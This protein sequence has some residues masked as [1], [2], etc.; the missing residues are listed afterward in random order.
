MSR[1]AA[2]GAVSTILT[3]S[4]R[5]FG[6]SRGCHL[7][8]PYYP[9][10]SGHNAVS[11]RPGWRS[12]HTA[13]ARRQAVYV[14]DQGTPSSALT[15][16]Y[17]PVQQQ[18]Q[19][20]TL[21]AVE[22]LFSA[23]GGLTSSA[24]SARAQ[25]ALDRWSHSNTPHSP[26]RVL[27]VGSSL[28]QVAL[29]MAALVDE[30]L[31]DNGFPAEAGDA[32]TVLH[33]LSKLPASTPLAFRY[34]PGPCQSTP[35]PGLYTLDRH[36][37]QQSRVELVV[38]I[39]PMASEATYD[40][41]YSSDAV[42]FVT[43]DYALG[44]SISA[45][46]SSR[47][48]NATHDLAARFADKPNAHLVVNRLAH[49]DAAQL[50]SSLETSLGPV[51]AERLAR[52]LISVSVADATAAH[53][54]FR[55]ALV[56]DVTASRSAGFDAAG[57]PTA[58]SHWDRFAA[59]YRLSNVGSI[60]AA[61]ES[62][63]KPG[64][65]EVLLAQSTAYLLHH[66]ADEA[67]ARLRASRSQLESLRLLVQESAELD[68]RTVQK[69]LERVWPAASAFTGQLSSDPIRVWRPA[70]AGSASAVDEALRQTSTELEDTFD[71][72]LQWWKIIW[73]VDDVRAELESACAGFAKSLESDLAYESG[74]LAT[75]QLYE[76]Q[77]ADL[78][79]EK[80]RK[81]AKELGASDD[82][83][84]RQAALLSNEAEA[85][86]SA[87][88]QTIEPVTLMQ[89]IERRRAQL[90]QS[91]GPID[92]F[93]SDARK[94]ALTT[95]GA[96]IVTTAGLGSASVLGASLSLDA[97]AASL[98]LEP[99][100]ALGLGLFTLTLAG[101]RLQGQYNKL[102]G[103]F[104]R[105]WDRLAEGLDSEL[106]SNFESVLRRQITGPSTFVASRIS[107]LVRSWS[108]NLA[109]LEGRVTTA[110]ASELSTPVQKLK[111]KHDV[112]ESVQKV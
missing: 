41:V 24:W 46:A 88:L 96:A 26:N 63:A 107:D 6:L 89:P 104:R 19:L 57:V 101:W 43:D 29:L 30:P 15:P 98:A 100:T 12:L 72:R 58:T 64:A 27:L 94:L 109:S 106:R 1:S 93:A 62:L 110:L 51:A 55:Q 8:N 66:C 97:S 61:F 14:A 77:Q 108:V 90:L 111:P 45:T 103:R 38:L 20:E 70:L 2:T 59:S 32:S 50:T 21:A 34:A 85:Y 82:K 33:L 91:G 37:L 81:S 92:R 112:D 3:R 35:Q 48:Q 28:S 16:L 80:F 13:E 95:S 39:D 9:S 23:N 44:S 49:R 73:K 40:A 60:L 56:S 11:H 68:E 53:A 65:S 7:P 76:V 69:T 52:S 47:P 87:Q 17:E 78:L 5:R 99:S 83:A 75:L 10:G 74:R 25:M 79:L 67:M 84:M 102:R 22:S 54:A 71:R 31:R 42:F 105:D 36:W 86:R 18:Q 4:T